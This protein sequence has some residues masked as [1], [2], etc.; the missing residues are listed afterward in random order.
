MDYAPVT[1]RIS[2]NAAELLASGGTVES[3]TVGQMEEF[4]KM[5]LSCIRTH[6]EAA[7]M[8]YFKELYRDFAILL[9]ELKSRPIDIVKLH[10]DNLAYDGNTDRYTLTYIPAKK[11]NYASSPRHT[12]SALVVQYLSKEAV[13]IILK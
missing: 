4:R 10:W 13:R 3:L 9:Y 6:G 12:K 1:H 8:T 11:K 7:K 2:E 5:D